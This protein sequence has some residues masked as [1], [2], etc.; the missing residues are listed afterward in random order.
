MQ[1]LVGWKPARSLDFKP[2]YFYSCESLWVGLTAAIRFVFWQSHQWC[3]RK[4]WS[5]VYISRKVF[6]NF[7]LLQWCCL[8]VLATHTLILTWHPAGQ[9]RCFSHEDESFPGEL[10]S[11]G[12]VWPCSLISNSLCLTTPHPHSPSGHIIFHTVAKL[13][14]WACRFLLVGG[15]DVVS[16][17]NLFVSHCVRELFEAELGLFFKPST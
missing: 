12:G 1:H 6:C 7:Y 11:R 15:S 8:L 5:W 9:F 3:S 10:G 13:R 16:P 2:L 17:G 4:I 14:C